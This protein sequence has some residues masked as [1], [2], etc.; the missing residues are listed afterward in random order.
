MIS[1][2][3]NERQNCLEVALTLLIFLFLKVRKGSKLKLF[4]KKIMK[5]Q[6]DITENSR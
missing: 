6:E 2:D 5:S 1:F 4:S 3:E